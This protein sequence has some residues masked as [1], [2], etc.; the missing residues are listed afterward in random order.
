MASFNFH[1]VVALAISTLLVEY[2]NGQISPPKKLKDPVRIDIINGL[3]S[4]KELLVHCESKTDDLGTQNIQ[5]HQNFS[6]TF[7]P[8][9]ITNTLFWCYTAPPDAK[10]HATFD[11]Y[12]EKVEGFLSPCQPGKI[13]TCV[14]I[15][16]D[17]GIYLRN[18][19]NNRYDELKYKWV[20]GR[21]GFNRYRLH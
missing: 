3:S 13:H 15:A 14:W 7:R 18:F 5:N 17:D 2:I 19:S 16:K 4:N 12:N 11:V 10:S 9:V 6:W 20:P 1:F 21:L 8:H